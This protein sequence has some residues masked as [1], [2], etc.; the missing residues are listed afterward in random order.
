MN[1]ISFRPSSMV[2]SRDN[3]S[4]SKLYIEEEDDEVRKQLEDVNGEHHEAAQKRAK[5]LRGSAMERGLGEVPCRHRH[6]AAA[7]HSALDVT[8]L[9]HAKATAAQAL[10]EA[11]LRHR[12]SSG[13]HAE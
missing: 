4:A 13:I 3:N 9:N 10:H 7:H 5:H 12:T 8:R 11:N 6:K 1:R 2:T